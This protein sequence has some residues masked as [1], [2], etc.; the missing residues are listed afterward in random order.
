MACGAGKIPE[1]A[2]T[3]VSKDRALENTNIGWMLE[4]LGKEKEKESLDMK[5]ITREKPFGEES[6]ES[7]FKDREGIKGQMLWNSHEG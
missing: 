7:L 1:M 5:R 4:E 2:Q 3:T 6:A